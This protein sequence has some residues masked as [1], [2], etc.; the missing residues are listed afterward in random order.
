MIR[1]WRGSDHRETARELLEG[2]AWKDV[3]RKSQQHPGGW[4]GLNVI[5]RQRTTVLDDFLLRVVCPWL[6]ALH[7]TPLLRLAPIWSEPVAIARPAKRGRTAEPSLWNGKS[8]Q[9]SF[10]NSTAGTFPR[11]KPEQSSAP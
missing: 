5:Y 2:R 8:A 11:V 1:E 4:G 3:T 7:A 6:V 10:A 9:W